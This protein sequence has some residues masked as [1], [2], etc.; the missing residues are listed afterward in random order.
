MRLPL[1]ESRDILSGGVGLMRCPHSSRTKPCS[2]I[3][4]TLSS[5]MNTVF[6]NLEVLVW[7]GQHYIS[8]D[9]EYNVTLLTLCSHNRNVG[10]LGIRTRTTL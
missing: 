3:H 6:G 9:C 1:D 10:L 4:V 2:V 5:T 8:S 7:Q